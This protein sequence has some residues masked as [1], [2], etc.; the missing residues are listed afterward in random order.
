MKNK[1]LLLCMMLSSGCVSYNHTTWPNGEQIQIGSYMSDSD[2][3]KS[4]LWFTKA[5]KR[6]TSL[7][8]EWIDERIKKRMNVNTNSVAK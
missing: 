4:H 6:V 3:N 2:I 7:N 1:I 8:E 5:G